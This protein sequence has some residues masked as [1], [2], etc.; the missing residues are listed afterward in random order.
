MGRLIRRATGDDLRAEA[1]YLL[2]VAGC[3]LALVAVHY[4]TWQAV[5]GSGGAEGGREALAMAWAVQVGVGLVAVALCG[6]GFR[7]A[8]WINCGGEGLTV[9]Q[10]DGRVEVSYEEI[11]AITVVSGLLYY[12]HYRRYSGTLSF[13]NRPQAE[14]LLV[15]APGFVLAL[16]LGD[17]DRAELVAYLELRREAVV[18]VVG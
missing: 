4:A 10:R 15:H 13:V 11:T 12:R 8:I 9:S 7:P 3:V 2:A 17:A 16:G 5:S 18:E 14:V 1:L 6:I